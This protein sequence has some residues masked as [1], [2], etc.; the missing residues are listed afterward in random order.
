[1]SR[2][3]RVWPIPIPQ[4]S[5]IRMRTHPHYVLG[6]AS[7]VRFGQ[8]EEDVDISS[9][10]QRFMNEFGVLNDNGVLILLFIGSLTM[11]MY[12]E[13]DG[14]R[15]AYIADIP[16]QRLVD[17]FPDTEPYVPRDFTSW[18]RRVHRDRHITTSLLDRLETLIG[19]HGW[20][21]YLRRHRLWIPS[22]SYDNSFASPY[23]LFQHHQGAAWWPPGFGG[24]DDADAN[25][26]EIL[27]DDIIG[28]M[29]G[30][31]EP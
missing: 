21:D 10:P 12:V 28:L 2:D 13:I 15:I 3:R 23:Q 4:A 5:P 19:A 18:A 25:D 26:D 22:F 8:P 31:F 16:T 24:I 11:D 27:D 17:F 7:P 14:E 30:E 9:Q 6:Q 29:S 20:I 1:M